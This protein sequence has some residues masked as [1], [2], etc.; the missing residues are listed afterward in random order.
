MSDLFGLTRLRS[1][2]LAERTEKAM[3]D[4]LHACAKASAGKPLCPPFE[5]FEGM[6]YTFYGKGRN[7]LAPTF[8][9]F[10]LFNDSPLKE[11]P[12]IF[13]RRDFSLDEVFEFVPTHLELPPDKTKNW[14]ADLVCP[15][16]DLGANHNLSPIPV[17]IENMIP[18]GLFF[19]TEVQARSRFRKVRVLMELI[20]IR[21]PFEG[22]PV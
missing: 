7:V 18:P 20:F 6:R 19:K 12:L 8:T 2:G 22:K 14:L 9:I 1:P 17:E 3:V 5:P 16:R 10:Q 11:N 15:M 4:T 13:L 21:K